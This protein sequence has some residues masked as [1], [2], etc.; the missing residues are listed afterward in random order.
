MRW[1]NKLKFSSSPSQYDGK[2]GKRIERSGEYKNGRST[3]GSVQYA[4]CTAKDICMPQDLG[5]TTW[6][7]EAV[8][9]LAGQ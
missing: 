5:Y 3:S 7:G 6:T 1:C 4:V 2:C 9:T 8:S